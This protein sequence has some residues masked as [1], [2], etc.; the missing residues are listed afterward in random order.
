MFAE[1]ITGELPA[2]VKAVEVKVLELIVDAK[3]AAPVTSRVEER[4]VAPLTV[5]V[6][7]IVGEDFN[8][9]VTESPRFASPPPV[10]FVPAEIVI[11]EFVKA[12]FGILVRVFVD[13]E[14]DLFVKVFVVSVPIKV[15]E[16]E[17]SVNFKTPLIICAFALDKVRAAKLGEEV[18]DTS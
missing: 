2:N 9:K 11:F 16:E 14:I 12:E 4:I 10:K 7:E 13:P 18:V 1:D 6:P 3:V 5:K 15:V 8:D 17:G